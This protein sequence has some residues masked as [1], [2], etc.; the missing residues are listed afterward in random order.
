M[1]DRSHFLILVN[2]TAKIT[3][4]L[5][6]ILIYSCIRP[7]NIRKGYEN[8]TYSNPQ[9][10]DIFDPPTPLSHTL[11]SFVLNLVTCVKLGG[12]GDMPTHPQNRTFSE[13]QR[14]LSYT[15]HY[16]A[17]L[18][19]LSKLWNSDQIIAQW[20]LSIVEMLCSGHLS[21]ADTIF[22][23]PLS[24]FYWNLP[25]H[26]D[27]S[28]CSH[29]FRGPMVSAIARFHWSLYFTRLRSISTKTY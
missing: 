16:T 24:I 4:T 14:G 7:K 20:N 21:V 26:A 8:V 22:G 1:V 25:L 27:T 29:L 3:K 28:M 19:I 15:F 2:V 18:K 23:T 10:L 9:R 17:K 6:F 5:I 13:P 12:I 11:S